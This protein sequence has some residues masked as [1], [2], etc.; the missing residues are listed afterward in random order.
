MVS[1]YIILTNTYNYHNIPE[2]VFC[3][4]KYNDLFNRLLFPKFIYVIAPKQDL[5]LYYITPCHD[6]SY[7]IHLGNN[8]YL[9]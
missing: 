3:Y 5:D 2:S 6:P 1:R 7:I 9:F 4:L 8:F